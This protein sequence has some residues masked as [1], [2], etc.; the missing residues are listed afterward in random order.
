MSA[1][2]IAAVH[3]E[4][5]VVG[6]LMHQR[7]AD[8]HALVFRLQPEDLT[9][10]RLRLVLGAVRTVVLDQVDPDPVVVLGELFRSGAAAS[11]P[12]G[13]PGPLLF[14]IFAAP[15]SIGTADHY[16]RVVLEF[17]WRRRVQEAGVRLQQ[18]AGGGALHDLE[19]LVAGEVVALREFSRRWRAESGGTRRLAACDGAA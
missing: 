14:E 1:E 11:F 2:V 18:A 12:D 13:G 16:L 5:A 19:Q 7:A 8:A 3:A 9:D 6:C 10:P 15:L 4:R 17:S